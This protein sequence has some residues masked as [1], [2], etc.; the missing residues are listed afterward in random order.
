MS[1]PPRFFYGWT[2]VAVCLVTGTAIWGTRYSYGVFFTS[3][4]H[5]FDLSRGATSAVFS[6]YMLLGSLV[7]VAWGLASD[8]WGPRWTV[9][10]MGAIT[11]ASLIISG[12]VNAYWQLFISYS[13]L[14]ALGTAGTYTV[15]MSLVSRWFARRRGLALGI[16]GA[17]SGL[18]TL[19]VSPLSAWLISLLGWRES[20]LV[21]GSMVIGLVVPLSMLLKRDPSVMGLQPDGAEAQT[22]AIVPSQ[23]ET[24]AT[25]GTGIAANVGLRRA[26]RT[27]S[28]W[29]LWLS[30]FLVAV[31]IHLVTTHVV[32]RAVD[33]GVATEVA[34]G[35]LSVIGGMSIPGRIFAGRASDLRGRRL[36]SVGSAALGAAAMLWLVWAPGS[37][38]FFLF[39]AAFGLSWGGVVTMITAMVSDVFG[40]RSM[41]SV[42]GAVSIA[43]VIGGAI[44]P[45]VGGYIFDAVGSYSPAFFAGAGCMALGAVLLAPVGRK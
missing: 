5:E 25:G 38:G 19:L 7:T 17:G 45:V 3:I 30:Y 2:V 44:G 6:A 27:L 1:K 12:Q 31:C 23:R 18:G 28:F 43:W 9:M 14:F 26:L 35:V 36:V 22:V 13:L 10:A 40:T 24:P 8:R 4:E 32:P 15:L 29:L 39:G 33:A 16:G 21:M 41:G 37:S 42:M 11:G 20:Y 34:A